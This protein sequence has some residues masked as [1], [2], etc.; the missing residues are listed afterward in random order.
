M[1]RKRPEEA[2]DGSFPR[3]CRNQSLG[4]EVIKP[5]TEAGKIVIA[6]GGG[7]IPLVKHDDGQRVGLK[8]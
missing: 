2:G 3:Q 8:P 4:T 7:G 6:S 5:V 1:L